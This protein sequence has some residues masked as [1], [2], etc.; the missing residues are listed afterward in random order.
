MRLGELLIQQGLLN[1][2]QLRT[3]LRTQ[4]FFGGHL[5]SILIDL[6]FVEEGALGDTLSRAAG[7]RYASPELLEDIPDEVIQAL[8]AK[9]AD[10]HKAIPLRI[11]ERRLHLAMLNPRDLVGLDEIAYLTGMVVI[12]YVAPEFRV[13]RALERYYGLRRER[14]DR[15]SVSGN[16][17]LEP[18]APQERPS[19]PEPAG[20]IE[21]GVGLDGL[22]LDAELSHESLAYET[23]ST[24]SS[25]PILD[26][27]PRSLDEWREGAA[28]TAP[29]GSP[30]AP[31]GPVSAWGGAAEDPGAPAPAAVEPEVDDPL[32]EPA[33]RLLSA[34]NRDD[35][36]RIV[37]EVA[38]R[39]FQRRLLFFLQRDR[40]VGWDGGG[41]G[42]SR[43]RLRS[44]LLPRESLS[45]FSTVQDGG[46][47]FRGPV[48]D[49]PSN[50][51]LFQDL[52]LAPPPEAFLLPLMLKGRVV[53]VLYG[54][55]GK[56][57]LGDVDLHL[58][59]RLRLQASI[60]LEILILRNKLQAV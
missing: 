5:G 10:R 43:E 55:N 21:A 26:R 24:G 36:A 39:L 27:L 3:A 12:P 47:P 14:S 23:P 30:A 16:V 60:A 22:P 46:G 25:D 15:I 37:L 53:S 7:V 52:G 2:A 45:L 58:L 51:R 11:H 17:D 57:S 9:V 54:D 49:L 4:E 44:V 40:I 32:R 18:P 31:A 34:V 41:D 50:R 29:A 35:I 59:G 28:A 42:V 33:T 20:A 38:G 6:G 8:P 56:A 1:E 13:F 19:P 48:V